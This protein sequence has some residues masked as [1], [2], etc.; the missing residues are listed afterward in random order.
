V[1]TPNRFRRAAFTAA[2]FRVPAKASGHARVR[3][4]APRDGELVTGEAIESLPVRDGAIEVDARDGR[5]IAFLAVVNRYHDAPPAVAF[6]R[7]LGLR[8]CAIA[9]SVAHDSHNV[10]AAGGSR[11][12][13]ARAVHAVFSQ[14][15]G[16]AR[17]DGEQ[18]QTLP[19]PIAGLMSDRPAEDVG[20]L[21]QRMSR[22]VGSS[23]QAPFMA[24][25]FLALLPIP[26]L[27]L[28]DRGL[29][30]TKNFRF[31]ELQV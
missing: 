31:A 25:S 26:A 24:L 20:E 13:L 2:D 8:G 16:L 10:V 17:I 21:Y 15:G 19:L 14:G 22:A 6:I 27:K 1:E 28:S 9:S 5:D 3:V 23:F 4:I 18:E 30:D 7:G 29:F 11:E 12:T